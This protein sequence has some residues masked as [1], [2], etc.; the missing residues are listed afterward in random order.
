M[1]ARP[2]YVEV[3]VSRDESSTSAQCSTVCKG[4]KNVSLSVT[5]ALFMEVGLRGFQLLA[6]IS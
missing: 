4:K 3:L 2:T 5:D 6:V 1:R